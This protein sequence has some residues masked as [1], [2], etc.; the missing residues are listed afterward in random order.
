MKD[1]EN[2]KHWIVDPEAAEVVK[3]IFNLCMEGRGPAQ[4]ATQLSKERILVPTAY[5]LQ[6]GFPIN[7]KVPDDPYRWNGDSVISILEHREYTGCTVA[8]KTYTNS[9]WD[10]AKHENPIENQKITPNTHEAI[11]SEEVFE[12]VQEIRKSRHRRTKT[13]KSTIFSGLV[14]CHD[15]GSPLCYSTTKDFENTQDFF[16]CSTHHKNRQKCVPYFIRSVVLEALVWEH[17]SSVIEYVVVHEEYFRR[18]MERYL[19][20]ELKEKVSLWKKQLTQSEKRIAEI[21]RLFLKLYEDNASGKISDSRFE[22]MSEAYESEQSDLKSRIDLLS[23][24]IQIQEEKTDNLNKFIETVKLHF[25]DKELNGYMLHELVQGIYIENA[26]IPNE[27]ESDEP[28]ID[29]VDDGEYITFEKKPKTPTAKKHR[30]RKIHIKYDFVGFIP[31][32]ELRKY[33]DNNR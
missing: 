4:I 9:I 2:A 32:K 22:T 3:H 25:E 24:S 31:I 18:Y 33:A 13:G 1:P 29:D 26:D 7:T 20:A 14:F 12:K 30:I 23:R 15:C 10:K 5:K 11:I 6:K 27:P 21:D 19:E 8:F 17:I 28:H 16:E